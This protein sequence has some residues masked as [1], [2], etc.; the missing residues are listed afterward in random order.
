MAKKMY[1]TNY[2]VAT[3]WLGNS[4]IMCNDIPQIDESVW[5][6]CALV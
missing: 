4:L 5:D 1:G 2:R 3:K 6:I